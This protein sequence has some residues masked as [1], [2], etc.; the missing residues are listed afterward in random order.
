MTPNKFRKRYEMC[1]KVPFS[2]QP[3][4]LGPFLRGYVEAM[5][6]TSRAEN[7]WSTGTSLAWYGIADITQPTLAQFMRDALYFYARNSKFILD[8][9]R[10]KSQYVAGRR[11]WLCR[12]GKL[13]GNKSWYK[14][15]RKACMS[16][17]NPTFALTKDDKV[18][19]IGPVDYGLTIADVLN[20]NGDILW[21]V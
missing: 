2:I 5:L 7:F 16:H 10:N 18:M 1:A 19:Q 15:V 6:D 4:D 14:R 11:L 12:V 21:G 13:R 20:N 9:E 8:K 3:D 17:F